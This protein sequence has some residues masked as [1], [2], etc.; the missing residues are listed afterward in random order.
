MGHYYVH[1]AAKI[2]YHCPNYSHTFN[3]YFFDIHCTYCSKELLYIPP[4]L[5]A[6]LHEQGF[7]VPGKG[8]SR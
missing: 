8:L 3:L 2:K 4:I 5:S 7:S 1:V 6:G